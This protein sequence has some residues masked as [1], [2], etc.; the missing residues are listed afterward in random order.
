[1][2]LFCK[3][4]QTVFGAHLASHSLGTAILSRGQSGRRVA[5]AT[6]LDL[7]PTLRSGTVQ[8]FP[9]MPSRC[10]QGQLYFYKYPLR[11]KPKGWRRA[12]CCRL[13]HTA[14][15]LALVQIDNCFFFFFLCGTTVQCGLSP[16]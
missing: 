13:M 8:T 14:K 7:S 15:L 16:P 3:N 2:F 9:C 6:H 11:T 12:A 4:T 5:S 10:R 1:M